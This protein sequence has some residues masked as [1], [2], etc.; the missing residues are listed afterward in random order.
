MLLTIIEIMKWIIKNWP[1]VTLLI[2]GIVACV[3]SFFSSK[4]DGEQK[5]FIQSLGEKNLLLSNQID[6]LTKINNSI[7]QLNTEIGEKIKDLTT[8]NKNLS[9][10]NIELSK[11][12]KTLIEKV[13]TLTAKSQE[14]IT[15]IDKRSKYWEEENLLSGELKIDFKLTRTRSVEGRIVKLGNKSFN[16]SGAYVIEEQSKFKV[17]GYGLS[18]DNINF[19]YIRLDVKTMTTLFNKEIYDLDGNL[20][21]EIENNRWRINRNFIGKFNYD[22][23]GVEIIDNQGKIVFSLNIVDSVSIRVQGIFIDRY[24]HRGVLIAG[25]LKNEFFPIKTP[26]N[27][28]EILKKKNLSYE[29]ALKEAIERVE[30]RQLFE[31]TGN[32]WLHKRKAN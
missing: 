26:E 25:Y 27:I 28:A 21:A 20:I 1:S 14:L 32:D 15:K 31:Y 7:G 19:L 23:E 11:Q 10:D 4:Q 22:E 9:I 16:V 2:V 8:E 17:K 30:F 3:A 5:N 24:F 6:S 13:E 12:T 18:Q 29:N